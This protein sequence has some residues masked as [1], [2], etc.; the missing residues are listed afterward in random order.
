[1]LAGQVLDAHLFAQAG[2]LA[3]QGAQPLRDNGFKVPLAQR[4]VARALTVAS[5]PTG[6]VA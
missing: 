3:V 6:G 5:D 4:A 2:A 1:M